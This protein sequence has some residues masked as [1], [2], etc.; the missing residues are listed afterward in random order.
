VRFFPFEL[1]DVL[2]K[3]V[4]NNRDNSYYLI[5]LEDYNKYCINGNIPHDTNEIADYLEKHFNKLYSETPESI[6]NLFYDKVLYLKYKNYLQLKGVRNELTT[7]KI[8]K[9]KEQLYF[10]EKLCSSDVKIFQEKPKHQFVFSKT[11]EL[12]NEQF[13]RKAEYAFNEFLKNKFEDFS[14]FGNDVDYIKSPSKCKI[15]WT[16]IKQES[17]GPFDFCI[18]LSDFDYFIE[19]KSTRHCEEDVFYLS[20]SELKKI[21]EYPQNFIVARLSFIED[22][23]EYTGIPINEEFYA[24]FFTV[25]KETLQIIKDEISNWREYYQENSI[26]FSIEHFN[27]AKPRNI[28]TEIFEAWE[29]IN[30]D[31][32]KDLEQFDSFV[33]KEFFEDFENK[34]AVYGENKNLQEIISKIYELYESPKFSIDFEKH[35]SINSFP[36]CPSDKIPEII[37]GNII[38]K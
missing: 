29:Y 10:L 35:T 18:K 6:I 19:V 8:I 33:Y 7:K 31:V 15:E 26:R 12:S 28:V 30:L 32:S 17:F 14:W 24:N 4:E 5:S 1:S 36:E 38:S 21:I 2:Y 9:I 22:N 23:K 11:K 37:K 34:H 16:N 25:K 27:K 3:I 13:G 20:L